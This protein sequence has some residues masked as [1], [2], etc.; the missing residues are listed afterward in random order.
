[1]NTLGWIIGYVILINLLGFVIMGLDK[2][3]ARNHDWRIAEST[4]FIIAVIGGS[5]GC[6]LGMYTFRH[7]TKHWYFKWGLPLIFII[8]LTIV[9]YIFLSPGIAITIM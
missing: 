5:L 2:S 9:A 7:K 1:M 6:I 3:R 4:F 8:E